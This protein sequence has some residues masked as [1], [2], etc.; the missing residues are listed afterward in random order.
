MQSSK[1]YSYLTIGV[2]GHRKLVDIDILKARI[3]DVLISY[4]PKAICSNQTF[5]CVDTILKQIK[6]KCLSSLA[7]G[8]D[9]LIAKEVLEVYEANLKIILP[10]SS[11]EYLKDFA[12]EISKSEF[13]FLQS[14]ANE[15]QTIEYGSVSN[16]KL[17][18]DWRNDSYRRAGEELVRQ[19]DIIIAIWDE[20]PARGI[21]GT[22]N[23]I[24]IAKNLNKPIYVISTKSF[25]IIPLN[26]NYINRNINIQIIMDNISKIGDTISNFF[27][28]PILSHPEIKESLIARLSSLISIFNKFDDQAIS[29]KKIFKR[30][31]RFLFILFILVQI[32]IAVGSICHYKTAFFSEAALLLIIFVMS[33]LLS[34]KI[35]IHEKW[36][37][38]RSLAEYLRCL[39]FSTTCDWKIDGDILRRLLISARIENEKFDIQEMNK[40]IDLAL[41]NSK[42]TILNFPIEIKKEILKYWI[43]GQQ[44]FHSHTYT[45]SKRKVKQI[46]LIGFFSFSIAMIFALVHFCLSYSSS[47][48]LILENI[49]TFISIVFPVVGFAFYWLR[50]VR[51]YKRI[52]I[53]SLIM[54]DDLT[55]LID[56]IDKADKEDELIEILVHVSRTM[57]QESESWAMLMNYIEIKST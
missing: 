41:L 38:A 15:K 39:I 2:I 29:Y 11:D 1:P 50:S 31:T 17:G 22:A 45:S 6:I 30:L 12:S 55:K 24:S 51:E 3:N 33:L 35:K 7:E 16:A 56:E 14:I 52:E 10:F 48:Y 4:I 18:Q 54:S 43:N 5:P 28:E 34:N 37:F 23:T 44:L 36:V 53:R 49:S 40:E 32:A 26:E 13:L 47:E 27:S 42:L 57:F 25:K 19:S 46:D 21:G 9:R 20:E 8:S